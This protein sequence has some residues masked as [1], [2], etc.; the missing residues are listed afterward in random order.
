MKPHKYSLRFVYI[1][2]VGRVAKFRSRWS[3]AQGVVTRKVSRCYRVEARKGL[4]GLNR[5]MKYQDLP[6]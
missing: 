3:E 6:S 1:V 2:L 5:I 4:V